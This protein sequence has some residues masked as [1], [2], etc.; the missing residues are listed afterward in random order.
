MIS[1]KTPYYAIPI[2][3]LQRQILEALEKCGDSPTALDILNQGGIERGNLVRRVNEDLVTDILFGLYEK[4]IV[5]TRQDGDQVPLKDKKR[6]WGFSS[7][8]HCI[9][10]K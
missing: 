1:T 9:I 8:L 5:T 7:D 4:G 6:Y 10:D 3:E 2:S